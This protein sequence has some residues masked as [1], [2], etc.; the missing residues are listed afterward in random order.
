M[1]RKERKRN[2]E[3]KKKAYGREVVNGKSFLGEQ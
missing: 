1:N 2:R 3:E